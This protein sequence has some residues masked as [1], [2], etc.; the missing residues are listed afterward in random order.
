MR[1]VAGGTGFL[2]QHLVN[3]WLGQG[4]KVTVIGRDAGKIMNIFGSQVE[5]VDWHTLEL[6][7]EAVVKDCELVVNLAGAPIAG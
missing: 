4:H 6:N 2:G 7:P 3:R 1:I 5:A